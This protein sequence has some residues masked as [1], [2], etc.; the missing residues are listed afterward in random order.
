MP[1]TILPGGENIS[2]SNHS[3]FRRYRK[4]TVLGE[5][6]F[7]C[8][9]SLKIVDISNTDLKD[10]YPSCFANS[11]LES[12]KLPNS[13]NSIAYNCFESCSKLCNIVLPDSLGYIGDRAFKH[14]GFTTLYLG[15]NIVNIGTE[16]FAES[17]GRLLWSSQPSIK[18]I[19]YRAFADYKG[20]SLFIP[21]SVTKI[22]RSALADCS[23]LREHCQ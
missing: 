19:G 1:R 10:L 11:G 22:E 2:V 8:C 20:N 18:T 9:G 21:D 14:C 13:L 5:A 16:A 23:N 6:A 17:N 15:P 7:Q 3:R 12:I 4:L